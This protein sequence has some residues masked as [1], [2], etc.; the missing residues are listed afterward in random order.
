MIDVQG[1]MGYLTT[2]TRIPTCLA[3]IS[4]CA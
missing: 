1:K 3:P 2:H 4:D